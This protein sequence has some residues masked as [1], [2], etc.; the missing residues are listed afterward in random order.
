MELQ[1]S[2]GWQENQLCLST[3]VGRERRPSC[4]VLGT[5][6][7]NPIG[8]R[9]Q[10]SRKEGESGRLPESNSMGRFTNVAYY[11]CPVGPALDPPRHRP[12][13]TAL[14]SHRSL[15]RA[16]LCRMPPI[17]YRCDWQLLLPM[18]S[19]RTFLSLEFPHPSAYNNQSRPSPQTTLASFVVVIFSRSVEPGELGTGPSDGRPRQ[20]PWAG[21]GGV[22]VD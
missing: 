13:E 20:A 8:R 10:K 19:V 16:S 7:R 4:S 18:W 14:P 22:L 6:V 12:A 15:S 21:Q 2:S 17:C 3:E 11:Q 9:F 5:S 1:Y